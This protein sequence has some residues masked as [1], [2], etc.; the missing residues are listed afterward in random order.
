[1][2]VI[3]TIKNKIIAMTVAEMQLIRM[4]LPMHTKDHLM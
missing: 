1:M 2:K 3:S 4:K